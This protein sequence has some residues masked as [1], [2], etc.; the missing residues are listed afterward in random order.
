M[1]DLEDMG[2]VTIFSSSG[3][4]IAPGSD[5]A[6]KQILELMPLVKGSIKIHRS[7]GTYKIPAWIVDEPSDFPRH[8]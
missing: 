8:P 5:P 2:N 1:S 7:R 3:S 6:V 4:I